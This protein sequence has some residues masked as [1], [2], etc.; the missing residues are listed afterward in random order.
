[1][2]P[3]FVQYVTPFMENLKTVLPKN[4]FKILLWVIILTIY[5][6]FI[7]AVYFSVNP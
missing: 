4:N 7:L 3:W 5:A 6:R 2:G 1:M